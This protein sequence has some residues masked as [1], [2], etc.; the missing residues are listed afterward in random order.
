MEQP[1]AALLSD[2]FRQVATILENDLPDLSDPLVAMTGLAPEVTEPADP[3]SK[4]LLP[5]AHK[6]EEIAAEYRRFT[7]ISLR[8]HKSQNLRI[9]ADI[10]TNAPVVGTSRN[11]PDAE[12][13]VAIVLNEEAAQAWLTATADARLAIAEE[14]GITD[15]VKA[16]QFEAWLVDDNADHDADPELLQR[17]LVYEVLAD[18]QTSLIA[19][20]SAD[21]KP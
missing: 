2:L 4:R 7:D 18:L 1:L 8:Q 3:V 16:A 10:L 11:D 19:A 12:P 21:L 14:L 6:D 13:V 5:S 17:G 15:A 9:A 20:V